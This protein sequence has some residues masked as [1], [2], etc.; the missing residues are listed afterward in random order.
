MHSCN[1]PPL[2]PVFIPFEKLSFEERSLQPNC[3]K[4]FKMV[5]ACCGFSFVSKCGATK[6]WKCLFCATQS[7][8]DKKLSL[9]SGLLK[10][11][12]GWV[13]LT[14]T[15]PGVDLLGWDKSYC[16]HVSSMECSG[17]I[18][19]KVNDIEGAEFNSSVPS[20][21]NRFMQDVR[22]TFKVEVQYGKVLEAQARDV[23]HI[24]ALLVGMPVM[25]IKSIKRTILS[26][27]KKHGF[28]NQLV[29]K[30]AVGDSPMN[31][32][33]A[34]AYVAKY[35][36]KGSQTLKTISQKTGEIRVGGYRDFTQSR[37]FGDTLKEI[38]RKRLLH[39]LSAQTV[40]GAGTPKI[41]E[42]NEVACGEQRGDE[43]ALD[44]YKKS[45]TLIT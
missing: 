8:M 20:N 26:L 6:D 43:V 22:R 4:P 1:L 33:K 14:L 38:K 39:Y 16:N 31:R 35:L 28:G 36:S 40:E 7:K 32:V 13:E 41:T 34:V 5:Y 15:A 17:K 18:G 44:N 23:L 10:S 12:M 37:N 3:E 42:G 30:R 24:H 21:W 11:P 29:V 45:Y 25:P 19:C 9:S 27:A 2:K